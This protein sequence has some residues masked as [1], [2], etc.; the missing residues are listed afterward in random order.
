MKSAD[1]LSEVSKSAHHVSLIGAYS[2][3]LIYSNELFGFLVS[4]AFISLAISST[5][6]RNKFLLFT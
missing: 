4:F 5:I 6:F 1:V 2:Y 3:P